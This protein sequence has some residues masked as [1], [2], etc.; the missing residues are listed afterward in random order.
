[1][2]GSSEDADPPR[3]SELQSVVDCCSVLVTPALN[4][5]HCRC[6]IHDLSNILNSSKSALQLYGNDLQNFI[7]ARTQQERVCYI[8]P[9][10]ASNLLSLSLILMSLDGGEALL[11]HLEA[12]IHTLIDIAANERK[13]FRRTFSQFKK[14]VKPEFSAWMLDQLE[15]SKSLSE[16]ILFFSVVFNNDI[17]DLVKASNI[18]SRKIFNSPTSTSIFCF[19]HFHNDFRKYIQTQTEETKAQCD[20][21]ISEGI[22]KA[23]RRSPRKIIQM[24]T[25]SK[26]LLIKPLTELTGSNFIPSL[27]RG[28]AEFLATIDPKTLPAVSPNAIP[29]IIFGKS[30]GKTSPLGKFDVDILN[31]S[32][33]LAI[34]LTDD[35]SLRSHFEF[36]RAVA[37]SLRITVP[38]LPEFDRPAHFKTTSASQNSANKSFLLLMA[39]LASIQLNLCKEPLIQTKG[40]ILI[41]SI[42]EILS[43]TIQRKPEVLASL[44]SGLFVL[45]SF[46]PET[47][48]KTYTETPKLFQPWIERVI[49]FTDVTQGSKETCFSF[50][51]LNVLSRNNIVELLPKPLFTKVIKI[52]QTYESGKLLSNWRGIAKITAHCIGDDIKKRDLFPGPLPTLHSLCFG[53]KKTR[54]KKHMEPRLNDISF[55]TAIPCMSYTIQ[56]AFQREPV[57]FYEPIIK[58]TLKRIPVDETKGQTPSQFTPTGLAKAFEQLDQIDN[59]YKGFYKVYFPEASS[60]YLNSDTVFTVSDFPSP[61]EPNVV[62]SQCIRELLISL[63]PPSSTEVAAPFILCLGAIVDQLF[64]TDKEEAMQLSKTLCCFMRSIALKHGFKPLLENLFKTFNLFRLPD[65]SC[66]GSARIVSELV[67][68][69]GMF[70]LNIRFQIK[71]IKHLIAHT[72]EMLLQIDQQF[73]T[74]RDLCVIMT[75]KGQLIL[76]EG[77]KELSPNDFADEIAYENALSREEKEK[78]TEGMTKRARAALVEQDKLRDKAIVVLNDL[79]LTF[80]TLNQSLC[81]ARPE[82]NSIVFPSIVDTLSSFLRYPSNIVQNLVTSTFVQCEIMMHPWPSSE[83][84]N[85][86]HLYNNALKVVCKQFF[87]YQGNDTDDQTTVPAQQMLIEL[88]S[89]FIIQPISYGFLYLDERIISKSSH[90]FNFSCK[91][92]LEEVDEPNILV[93]RYTSKLLKMIKDF[94]PVSTISLLLPLAKVISYIDDESLIPPSVSRKTNSLIVNALHCCVGRCEPYYLHLS[95][96]SAHFVRELSSSSSASSQYVTE[97]LKYIG[98]LIDS[99]ENIPHEFILSLF[100]PGIEV[101][102]VVLDALSETLTTHEPFPLEENLETTFSIYQPLG[103]DIELYNSISQR[104]VI[105]QH[106]MSIPKLPPL[107]PHPQLLS[108]LLIGVK[109]E[110]GMPESY[111]FRAASLRESLYGKENKLPPISVILDLFLSVLMHEDPTFGSSAGNIICSVLSMMD[112]TSGVLSRGVETLK[113]SKKASYFI[114]VP[115]ELTGSPHASVISQLLL[116]HSEKTPSSLLAHLDKLASSRCTI[117]RFIKKLLP[118]AAS[119]DSVVDSPKRLRLFPSLEPSDMIPLPTKQLE[120]LRKRREDSL[121]SPERTFLSSVLISYFIKTI[122]VDPS[123]IGRKEG[124]STILYYITEIVDRFSKL[125]IYLQESGRGEDAAQKAI[126]SDVTLAIISHELTE[127]LTYMIQ[128]F[129]VTPRKANTWLRKEKQF[130]SSLSAPKDPNEQKPILKHSPFTRMIFVFQMIT[131]FSSVIP[132]HETRENILMQTVDCMK[133]A[134]EWIE[135]DPKA[136]IALKKGARVISVLVKDAK[137][138]KYSSTFIVQIL[139]KVHT[140]S[141]KFAKHSLETIKV[142]KIG[143]VDPISASFLLSGF[144]GSQGI[145][146]IDAWGLLETLPSLI[147]DKLEEKRRLSMMIIAGISHV[148]GSVMFPFIQV[149][150]ECVLMGVADKNAKVRKSAHWALNEIMKKIT[151]YSARFLCPTLLKGLSSSHSTKQKGKVVSW[152][153]TVGA[154]EVIRALVSREVESQPG[155]S[156]TDDHE[157]KNELIIS[158][159]NHRQILTLLLPTLLPSVLQALSDTQVDIRNTAINTI[160]AMSECIVSPDLRPFTPLIVN[161]LTQPD[162]ETHTV[163]QAIVKQR[164]RTKIDPT[165]LSLLFPILARGLGHRNTNTRRNAAHI[166]ALLSS[167]CDSDVIL[168]YANDLLKQLLCVVLDVLPEVRHS[169]A[170]GIANLYKLISDIQSERKIVDDWLVKIKTKFS[171]AYISSKIQ[172]KKNTTTEETEIAGY[173]AVLSELVALDP[174]RLLPSVINEVC[175]EI[176]SACALATK[177]TMILPIELLPVVRLSV[178]VLMCLPTTVDKALEPY[179]SQII[180]PLLSALSCIPPS[181]MFRKSLRDTCMRLLRQLCTGYQTPYSV[182]ENGNQENVESFS[183]TVRICESLIHGLV[184]LKGEEG[185]RAA[186]EVLGDVLCVAAMTQKTRTSLDSE[187]SMKHDKSK[188]KKEKEDPNMTARQLRKQKRRE[189][190]KERISTLDIEDESGDGI[191]VPTMALNHSQEMIGPEMFGTI[192]ASVYEGI[193]DTSSRI[194]V[195]ALN[196]WKSLVPQTTKFLPSIL[197]E[198]VLSLLEGV[199]GNVYIGPESLEKFKPKNGW[200]ILVDR[201]SRQERAL[202]ALKAVALKHQPLIEEPLKRAIVEHLEPIF[203]PGATLDAFSTSGILRAFHTLPGLKTIPSEYRIPLYSFLKHPSTKIR[204]AASSLVTNEILQDGGKGIRGIINDLILEDEGLDA[205]V[206]LM[207]ENVA[208]LNLF[209]PTLLKFITKARDK[210]GGKWERA[211]RVLE[212]LATDH[213][214]LIYGQVES[215]LSTLLSEE[216]E[217]KLL[218]ST[219]KKIATSTFQHGDMRKLITFLTVFIA[220]TN[221]APQK[222][223]SF[224]LLSLLMDKIENQDKETILKRALVALTHTNPKVSKSASSIIAAV[225]T[226]TTNPADQVDFFQIIGEGLKTHLTISEINQNGIEAFKEN[227]IIQPIVSPLI[228]AFSQVPTEIDSGNFKLNAAELYSVLIRCIPTPTRM[229]FIPLGLGRL[230]ALLNSDRIPQV[231]TAALK[232]VDTLLELGGPT[233]VPFHPSLRSVLSSPKCL[234]D[235]KYAFVRKQSIST[236]VTLSKYERQ[237]EMLMSFLVAKVVQSPIEPSQEIDLITIAPALVKTILTCLTEMMESIGKKIPDVGSSLPRPHPIFS[238]ADSFK[239]AIIQFGTHFLHSGDNDL[240]ESAIRLVAVSILSA[241]MREFVEIELARLLTTGPSWQFAASQ[242]EAVILILNRKPKLFGLMDSLVKEHG[243]LAG[244]AFNL[245]ETWTN[246]SVKLPV[247][248]LLSYISIIQKK[249]SQQFLLALVNALDLSSYELPIHVCGLVC[250]IVKKEPALY[251]DLAISTLPPLIKNMKIK[252]TPLKIEAEK[253]IACVLFLREGMAKTRE[254]SRYFE[255]IRQVNFGLELLRQAKHIRSRI[256]RGMVFNE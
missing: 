232:A 202:V 15:R 22:S 25:S 88:Q 118:M 59:F 85:A 134:S 38:S 187:S 109:N 122:A 168:P 204:R 200:G 129:G 217:H 152:R 203:A 99:K 16:C 154:L 97:G 197:P 238:K 71:L 48:A 246:N 116:L 102:K 108:L 255:E 39:G 244:L 21:I 181:T 239:R 47:L 166:T 222:A 14:I 182:D 151:P 114:Q 209:L 36:T 142:P 3:K 83:W 144:L 26:I 33:L 126:E 165:G 27:I 131:R 176:E 136:L 67:L 189:L 210:T 130:I 30:D 223:G 172:E 5:H 218:F 198:L 98:M 135:K 215:I 174:Q 89:Q 127:A 256:A 64:T 43:V 115:T 236:L 7:L 23:F 62:D 10:I 147:T 242:V 95:E 201:N 53:K 252:Y 156:M 158:D 231:R 145:R 28:I 51:A 40:P 227:S 77:E 44:I 207:S 18:I 84:I 76:G 65:G 195:I 49:F 70:S 253:A 208:V 216:I 24:F 194:R 229:R 87:K 93:Y 61:L 35:L 91:P 248:T 92:Q 220:S 138:E 4:A 72:H 143:A 175:T 128:E 86:V 234:L 235:V 155:E 160:K 117:L 104:K 73:P 90:L 110:P 243:S 169:A 247:F 205:I 57:L 60:K 179:L 29:R 2:E 186:A 54:S 185:R 12:S 188:D 45:R 233:T 190:M 153:E 230:I 79:I 162:S 211:L 124:L 81:M 150:L 157:G 74:E 219:A 191:F 20:A 32:E 141:L 241:K 225:L 37:E 111:T 69:S 212:I 96:L 58:T 41:R 113:Q 148:F 249:F 237:P 11:P 224:L 17:V 137:Y 170:T 251:R 228:S 80:M 173:A 254:I 9:L 193:F 119:L 31:A 55:L 46:N 163:L 42:F 34:A 6:A 240:R 63:P 50:L 164:F 1:M 149:I 78:K 171:T 100:L 178:T 66:P 161:A 101:K 82:A 120:K 180:G 105:P 68:L 123:A 56:E 192:M 75:P 106:F 19:E 112:L 167:L 107:E 213:P 159:T 8:T 13:A 121:K 94:P 132:T 196:I 214:E 183:S 206:A 221:E 125:T 199:Q 245:L 177:E 250:D 184:G 139:Q 103:E 226:N 133:I 52:V 140:K 146:S